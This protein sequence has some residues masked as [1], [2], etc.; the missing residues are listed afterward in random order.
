MWNFKLGWGLKERKIEKERKKQKKEKEKGKGIET[1]QEV[2]SQDFGSQMCGPHQKSS[3]EPLAPTGTLQKMEF[4]QH[5]APMMEED[6][7]APLTLHTLP[8]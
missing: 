3:L 5:L 4:L 7:Q 6:T 1:E 8:L 2:L